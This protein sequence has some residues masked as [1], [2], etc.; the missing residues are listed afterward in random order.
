MQDAAISQARW[1]N[2]GDALDG[3]GAPIRAYIGEDL[4]RAGK[5]MPEQHAVPLSES[6]S[7]ATI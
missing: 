5:Q 2:T 4:C 1:G 7:V 6:F 3:G